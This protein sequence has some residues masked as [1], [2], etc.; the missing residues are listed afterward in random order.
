VRAFSENLVKLFT[1]SFSQSDFPED[2]RVLGGCPG[3]FGLVQDS[4]QQKQT[5][6]LND[7]GQLQFSC[8]IN[9]GKFKL[10]KEIIFSLQE[11]EFNEIERMKFKI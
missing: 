5:F 9:L 11:V 2:I 8:P 10:I 6:T 1:G 3:I 4:I 7:V